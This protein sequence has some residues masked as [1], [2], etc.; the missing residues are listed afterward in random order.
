M[1]KVGLP[2]DMVAGK[3]AQDGLD[4]EILN[5]N[6]FDLIPLAEPPKPEPPPPEPP[7]VSSFSLTT[8]SLTLLYNNI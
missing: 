2:K 8:H 1:L 6:P 4:P 7:K 5:K 3:M